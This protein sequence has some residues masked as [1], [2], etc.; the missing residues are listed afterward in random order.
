MKRRLGA[1]RVS[2]GG[3]RVQSFSG[4]TRAQSN[5]FV[6]PLQVSCRGT[7]YPIVP[8]TV[9]CFTSNVERD[10]VTSDIENYSN[11]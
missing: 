4:D 3:I 11:P 9:P 7:Y 6:Q 5:I 2:V 8:C 10:L 1:R